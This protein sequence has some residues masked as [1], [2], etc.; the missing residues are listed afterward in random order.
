[1]EVEEL[2]VQVTTRGDVPEAAKQYAVEKVTHLARLTKRPILF[3]Q[4]KLS[5]EGNPSRERPALAEASFDVNG[6]HLRAHV[7]AHDLT[8]AVDLLTDRLRRRLERSTHRMDPQHRPPPGNG[9]WRHGDLPTQRPEYFDRPVDEREIV[10]HKTFALAP[11]TCEEA[12]FDLDMLGHDFYLFTDIETGADSVLFHPEGS[13]H[14][15]L[16]QAADENRVPESCSAPVV[17]STQ[18]PATMAVS[19]AEERLDVSK[20]PFVF[21]VNV[22]TGRG[23]V[24]Y[25]RYDGH[26]GLITPA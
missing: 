9:R 10:R 26:Y 12:A 25:R 2:E 16:M 5:L 14:L 1:M 3:V 15:E 21:F 11:M 4:V 18:R 13:D 22:E 17:A 24:I 8:E 19:E 6:R 20:E 23:N 7:A